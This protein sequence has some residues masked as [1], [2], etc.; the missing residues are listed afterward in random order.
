MHSNQTMLTILLNLKVMKV[1]ELHVLNNN[2]R[3]SEIQ[4]QSRVKGQSKTRSHL[5]HMAPR[6]VCVCVQ[7]LH[8]NGPSDCR[9]IL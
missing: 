1:G 6:S 5:Y 9:Q 2:F 4:G 3:E 8:P 7:R